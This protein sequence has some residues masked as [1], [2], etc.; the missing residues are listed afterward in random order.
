MAYC[1]IITS[2]KVSEDTTILLDGYASRIIRFV[3]GRNE[4]PVKLTV[5]DM[6]TMTA[7]DGDEAYALVRV[8]GSAALTI[9]QCELMEKE[10]SPVIAKFLNLSKDKIQVAYQQTATPC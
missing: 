4:E 10:F 9:A 7:E 8:K 2:R 6:Q 1:E 3:M 5:S